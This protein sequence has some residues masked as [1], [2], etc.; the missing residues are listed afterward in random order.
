MQNF[1]YQNP[2]KILFGEGQIANLP[3]QIPHDARILLLYGGGSIKKNGIYDQ[4]QKAFSH[5]H[6][7]EFSGIPANPEYEVLLQAVEKI[8]EQNLDYILAVGGGSVIDGAKFIAAAA[9]YEGDDPWQLLAKRNEI[10][11]TDAVPFSAILTLP[12]TG[13]EMNSGAVVSRRATKEK[14]SFNSPLLYPKCSVLDPTV[15]RSLP[16]RQLEN[17]I[18]DAFTHVLEQYMTYPAGGLLQDRFAEGI[19]QTLIAVSQPVLEDQSNY[20]AAANFMWSCTMALNGLI[21][22]GVPQ[23]WGVH[24]IGHEFTALFG[25]DHA[26]TL[27]IV[28]PRYYEHCFED[29]KAKLVQYAERVWQIT[30]GSD[31]EKAHQAIQKTETF[32]NSIGIKT[33]LSDYT[34]DY[35]TAP[36]IIE[37]RFQDRGWVGIGENRKVTPAEVK[38]IVKRTFSPA[39]KFD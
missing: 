29:K 15:I 14:L 19:L 20:E 17:G 39:V 32:F 16:R 34:E 2:T 36:E 33:A 7:V 12:A 6:L 22:Q 31:D 10:K 25:I 8:K 3:A 28:A 9:K 38:D 5:F 21:A 1:I 37:K 27:A 30:S 24:A 26:R 11:I 13:S 18:A 23:D 4:I 35:A